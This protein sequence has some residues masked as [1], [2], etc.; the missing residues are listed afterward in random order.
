LRIGSECSFRFSLITR[1]KQVLVSKLKH[2]GKIVGVSGDRS[3]D[4]LA[5]KEAHVGFSMGVTG[6]EVEKE[7]S[8]IVLMDGNSL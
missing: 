4:S 8:D 3:N 2:F 5:L 7:A 1:N 6:M